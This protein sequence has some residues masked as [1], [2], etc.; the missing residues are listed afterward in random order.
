[1]IVR[2]MWRRLCL[3]I[4]IKMAKLKREDGVTYIEVAGLK[5]ATS[6]I[7]RHRFNDLRKKKCITVSDILW[8]MGYNK[9]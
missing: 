8:A 5:I 7:N 9:K 3:S 6:K 2:K 1:M 4:S